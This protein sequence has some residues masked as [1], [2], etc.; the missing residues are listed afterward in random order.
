MRAY[1]LGTF[2]LNIKMG[3]GEILSAVNHKIYTD[4]DIM[5]IYGPTDLRLKH[6]TSMQIVGM[7]RSGKSNLALEIAL[8]RHKVYDKKQEL[9]IYLYNNYQSVFDKIKERDD[10][11]IFTNS[12]DV[13]E[14]YISRGVGL[15]IIF[16]DFMLQMQSSLNEYISSFFI[17][18]AHHENLSLILL[19]QVLYAKNARILNLNAHYLVIFRLTRDSRQIVCL[20]SQMM[21]DKPRFVYD[22]YKLATS[23][24]YSYLCIDLYPTTLEE[25]RFRSSV[26]VNPNLRLYV[27]SS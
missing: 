1:H 15:L 24:P 19:Q 3:D 13:L 26:F 21:P 17:Q 10:T 22:C 4:N 23:K 12:I 16:D 18:R 25:A 8:N 2:L 14:E 7:S 11:I 5:E 27:P 20:G 6:G 9:C